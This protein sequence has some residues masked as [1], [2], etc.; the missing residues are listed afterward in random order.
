MKERLADTARGTPMEC[1]PPS[2]RE[3]VGFFM[4]A[5]S[6]AKARPASTSPPTVLSSISRPSIWGSSSTATI[7][8]ITCSYLVVLFWA[9]RIKCPSISPM[10]VRQWMV[11][12]LHRVVTEPSSSKGGW[13]VARLS[14]VSSSFSWQPSSKGLFFSVSFFM[15]ASSFTRDSLPEKGENHTGRRKMCRAQETHFVIIAFVSLLG[16]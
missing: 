13:E 4:P 1:P 11:W 7:W 15:A 9:G 12:P 16:K 8:G 2:T 10:M 14:P 3:T 6:S 5:T